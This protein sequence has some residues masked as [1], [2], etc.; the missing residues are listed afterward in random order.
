MARGV[1]EG[2][3]VALPRTFQL[4]GNTVTTRPNTW[5]GREAGGLAKK[6]C[7][8]IQARRFNA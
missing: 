4:N 6:S 2:G 7:F 1:G 3:E 5:I 8:S